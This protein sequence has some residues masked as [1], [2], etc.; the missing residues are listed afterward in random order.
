MLDRVRHG[1]PLRRCLYHRIRRSYEESSNT[2]DNPF[3]IGRMARKRNDTILNAGSRLAVPGNHPA[4]LESAGVT[5]VVFGSLTHG[6]P[7]STTGGEW[8]FPILAISIGSEDQ[9]LPTKA[10]IAQLSAAPPP[11]ISSPMTCVNLLEPL[12]SPDR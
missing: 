5:L 2:G 11:Y 9:I 4:G 7:S 10:A 8:I 3:I 1:N 6:L 12:I